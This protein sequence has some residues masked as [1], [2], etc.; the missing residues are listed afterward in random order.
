MERTA[1]RTVGA[2]VAE[3]LFHAGPARV[4]PEDLG[5][6]EIDV[7][8]HGHIDLVGHDD[9]SSPKLM[10]TSMS[11]SW[12]LK[13][14][15]DRSNVAS[16]KRW[17]YE[18]EISAAVSGVQAP[19]RDAASGRGGLVGHD[20]EQQGKD[21]ADR[22]VSAGAAEPGADD[23][24]DADDGQCRGHIEHAGY[25]DA[26]EIGNAQHAERE[27]GDA[28]DEPPSRDGSRLGRGADTTGGWGWRGGPAYGPCG[29]NGGI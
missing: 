12:P 14:T 13:S 11:T 22:D 19:S 15:L 7:A 18:S 9:R 28:E 17:L 16:P 23:E 10:P 24:S 21:D 29:A 20:R 6:A 8:V 25:R 1:A 5:V 27:Q 2:V 4:L 26:G 3:R